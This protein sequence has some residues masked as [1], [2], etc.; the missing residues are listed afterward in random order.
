[1]AG[2]Q[3]FVCF[4]DDFCGASVAIPT[5]AEAG[6]PW[7]VA[8]TSAAGAPTYT[9][10]TGINGEV[11]LTMAADSEAENLCFYM[12]DDL[13]FDIDLIQ[14]F[15]CRVKMGQAAVGAVTDFSFG[16]SSARN[17]TIDTI[18][19]QALF[20]VVGADSTTAVV[21]ESDDGTVNNDDVATGTTLIN[22]YKKFRISFTHGTSDVRFYID[23]D[24]VAAGTT[25]DM[26]N[27][28]AGLQP[29]FQL[30]KASGTD[31][32][33][34]VIDYVKIVSNRSA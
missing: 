6:F 19:E 12:D 34:V 15:E 1:M 22:A 25:F 31:A 18:G 3:D 14:Y 28:T 2:I 30:Q 21:V 26:S 9:T 20:R 29:M 16:L 24:R 32:S 10:G 13:N 33:A 5:S 27:Y 11:T 8:D 17:D 4:E 7:I 23:D